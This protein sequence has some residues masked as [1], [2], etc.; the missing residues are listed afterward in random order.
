MTT[1][2]QDVITNTLVQGL[3]FIRLNHRTFLVR[4][5]FLLI[6]NLPTF[7][8]THNLNQSRQVPPHKYNQ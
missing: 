5:L 1:I 3:D 6:Q 4:Q 8:N 7:Q 2:L